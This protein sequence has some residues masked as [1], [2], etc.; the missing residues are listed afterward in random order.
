MRE[1]VINKRK[2]ISQNKSLILFKFGNIKNNF[3]TYFYSFIY[4]YNIYD[5]FLSQPVLN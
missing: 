4:I 1:P 2:K 5:F 3:Q